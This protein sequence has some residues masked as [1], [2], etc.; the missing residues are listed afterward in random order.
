M[1]RKPLPVFPGARVRRLAGGATTI[2]LALAF[3]G[4]GP[5][6]FAAGIYKWTDANGQVHYGD[7]PTGGHAHRM[8][9][10]D[11][12]VIQTNHP[13]AQQG[14]AL[15]PGASH[16]TRSGGRRTHR[17]ARARSALKDCK[18]REVY[19]THLPRIE[20]M[21]APWVRRAIANCRNNR[22][23][24]CK[25]PGE[26]DKWRPVRKP[27]PIDMKAP[28]VKR[29]IKRC[30]KNRGVDCEDPDYITSM[31]PLTRRERERLAAL[32]RVRRDI[33]GREVTVP[34]P[35]AHGYPHAW[36]KRND[37]IRWMKLNGYRIAKDTGD[38]IVFCR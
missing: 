3:A 15:A 25:N 20:D 29:A 31:R 5:A 9:V 26:L 22:G 1:A 16:E 19:R 12:N 2:A 32:P 4:L 11:G 13:D 38:R 18:D 24:D 21:N 35:G 23:V 7:A 10:P 30:K 28:W 6:G 17:V 33:T 36:D 34:G 14:R 37:K 27:K 8:H